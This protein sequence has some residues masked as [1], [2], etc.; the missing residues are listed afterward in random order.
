M[1][2]PASVRVAGADERVVGVERHLLARWRALY[3]VMMD[4][5]AGVASDGWPAQALG[6]IRGLLRAREAFLAVVTGP[7][8]ELTLY[9][10]GGD[11]VIRSSGVV[12]PGLVADLLRRNAPLRHNETAL[13]QMHDQLAVRVRNVCGVPLTDAG[14]NAGALLAVNKT[15][16]QPFTAW[17]QDFLSLIGFQMSLMLINARL[18]RQNDARLQEN[19][20]ELRKLNEVLSTQHAA[21]Q[22]S[23]TIHNLLTN[24]VLEGHGLD[25]ITKSIGEMVDNSVI[26]TD[27][28]LSPLAVHPKGGVSGVRQ[29]WDGLIA[30][31]VCKEEILSLFQ[32]KRLIRLPHGEPQGEGGH[33]VVLP[34]VAGKDH[35]GF[36]ATL[37]NNHTLSELDYIALEHA[38]TVAALELLKQKAAFTTELRLRKNFLKELMQGNYE[39][40]EGVLWKARQLGLDFARAHRVV[41]LEVR[42]G[43]SPGAAVINSGDTGNLLHMVDRVTKAVHPSA[44]AAEYNND[45]ILLLPDPRGER[46][47]ASQQP[48]AVLDGVVS[49][50]S[51]HLAGAAW[52]LGI[53]TPC[54]RV[55]DFARSYREAR[56]CIDIARSLGRRDCSFAYEQLGIFSLLDINR[57]AFREF[58]A[59]V[60]GPLLAYEEKHGSKLLSTL[61]LYYR[62]KG[63]ILKAA[64][65]GFLSPGTLRYRLKKIGEIAH[66]DLDDPETNLQVQLALKLVTSIR[67]G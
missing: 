35:L 56:A 15:G 26:V 47:K 23:L 53:G 36:V 9:A 57:E 45:L 2:R 4:I 34:V 42:A 67:N 17:D 24:L 13:L 21:L 6:R 38:C 25:A 10:G 64:R 48:R 63:N 12:A 39:S 55:T 1:E 19:L 8:P 40:E 49:Q 22:K 46:N 29:T 28:F 31:P 41:V 50:L 37:E 58:T 27:Q 7:G 51:A 44:L 65:A 20:A 66:I 33:L 30:D 14:R 43:A 60:I 62:H 59:R 16:G 61:D 11:G 5:Q 18:S 54:G 52:W 32:G 3:K